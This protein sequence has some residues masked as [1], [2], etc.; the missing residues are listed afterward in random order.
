MQQTPLLL[1]IAM[2]T[3]VAILSYCMHVARLRKKIWKKSLTI[4]MEPIA[5]GI[6]ANLSA[7]IQKVLEEK[8]INHRAYKKYMKK[9]YGHTS[10][11]IL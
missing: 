5:T 9:K 1:I 10:L 3:L 4:E 7:K 2:A 8:G 11:N 6:K